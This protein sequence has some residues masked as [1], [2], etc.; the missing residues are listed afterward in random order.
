[1]AGERIEQ[2]PAAS[3]AVT[4]LARWFDQR[5]ACAWDEL[6]RLRA[7]RQEGLS[8]ERSD[9][10]PCNES[11]G[12]GGFPGL[13]HYVD[14]MP[15]VVRPPVVTWGPAARLILNQP[16]VHRHTNALHPCIV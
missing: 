6:A 7:A 11:W 13:A 3:P 16:P 10:C 15:V 2:L 12:S 4:V 5:L 1:M 8:F 9:N 14:G